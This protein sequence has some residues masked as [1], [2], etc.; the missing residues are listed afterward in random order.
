MA[1]LVPRG[2][3]EQS[4]AIFRR[5]AT[6]PDSE[7]SEYIKAYAALWIIDLARLRKQPPDDIALQYLDSLDGPR[8]YVQLARFALGRATRADLEPKADAPGKRC[9]LLFYEAMRLLAAGDRAGATELWRKVIAT[10]MLGYFEYDMA[11]HYLRHGPPPAAPKLGPVKKP[12]P[13]PPARRHGRDGS[14]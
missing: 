7:V 6:R 10:G 12:R 5:G 3:L 4:A 2:Y 13:A 11:A 1:Y 8:W 9:E 14:L